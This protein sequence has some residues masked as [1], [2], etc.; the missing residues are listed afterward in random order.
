MGNVQ[1]IYPKPRYG[2]DLSREIKRRPS[3]DD[4][5]SLVI[6]ESIRHGDTNNGVAGP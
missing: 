5:S 3:W 6:L 1:N 4:V 2:A